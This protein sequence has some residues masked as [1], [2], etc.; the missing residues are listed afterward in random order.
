MAKDSTVRKKLRE[1]RNRRKD[2]KKAYE[3]SAMCLEIRLKGNGRDFTFPLGYEA[4]HEL[5]RLVVS[6]AI[7]EMCRYDVLTFNTAL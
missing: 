6:F 5:F 3:Y 1:K 4:I 2:N 7:S